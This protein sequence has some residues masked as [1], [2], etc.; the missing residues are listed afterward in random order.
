MKQYSLY[1]GSL[2]LMLIGQQGWASPEIKGYGYGG[3]MMNGSFGHGILGGAVMILFWVG[4]IVLTVMAVRWLTNNGSKTKQSSA[5]DIL[6][7]RLAR[8]EID[9]E[10]YQT[11]KTALED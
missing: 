1:A 8:G 7:E 3:H 5:F 2:A 6:Q 4:A 10:E 9:T 11:R